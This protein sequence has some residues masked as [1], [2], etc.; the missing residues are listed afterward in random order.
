[1]PDCPDDTELA[2]F[3]NES[4]PTERLEPVSGH[5]DGCP[6]CQA[7]L[8]RLTEQTSG[9]VARYKELQPSALPDSRSGATASPDAD[10]QI[11]GARNPLAALAHAELPTVPGFDVAAEIGRGGMGVVYRARHRR[12][13]RLVALKMILAGTAADPRVVQ[14]FM[15][16]AEV[17]ARIQHPQVVQVFEVGTYQGP[18]GVPIPYLAMELLEGGSLGRKLRER[19]TAPGPRWPAPRAAAELIEGLARA[20][21][22]A[23]LRGV[24]H[25]D[26]K[27]GNI[28]FSAEPGTASA[29]PNPRAG[30]V[31]RSAPRAPGSAL[32][33]V[34]D[35]GLAKFTRDAGADLTQSGQVVGTPQYMAPEQAAGGKDL[36]P[37]ADVYALG[38]ILYECLAGRP[39]FTGAE[40]ISVLLKVVSE[41]PPD[42]RALRPEVP[43]DLA[44][45][46][47]KCLEKDPGRRYASA[48]ALADDLRL[49]LDDRPTLARPVTNR[50]RAWLWAKRNPVVAGL[51]AALGVVL[52]AAFV[53]VASLWVKAERTARDERDAKTEA[54]RAQERADGETKRAA[55]SLREVQRQKARLEFDRAVRSCEE[56]RVRDGLAQFLRTAELAEETGQADLARVARVNLAAW[57]HELPPAPRA[58]PHA[59]QPRAVAFLP[60][61][62]LV[63]AGRSGDLCLWNTA[64]GERVPYRSD[65]RLIDVLG[66]SLG[67]TYWTVAVSP[68]GR[69]L[70]AGAS[71]GLVT[72]W[73]VGSPV[74]RR[75]F[76]VSNEDAW[77]VGFSSD[78]VLWSNDGA[79]GLKRW[80][81]AAGPAPTVTALAPNSKFDGDTVQ[82]LAVSRDGKRV[83][84]GDRAARVREWDTETAAVAHT[85]PFR[86]WGAKVALV[87]S[88]A[89]RG[90]I[91]DV[92]VSPDGKRLAATGTDGTV[93]VIDLT[94]GA[95]VLEL[96]LAGAY[97][98][99]VAFAPNRPLLVATD[100]DGN[101]RL[102]RLD[103]GQAVGVPLRLPGEVTRPRFRPDSDEFAVPAGTAVYLSGAREV[104]GALLSA[105]RGLRVRGL[106]FSPTGDR[107]VA[108][109]DSGSYELFDPRTGA[110]LQYVPKVGRSPLVVR[111][112]PV[113]ARVFAGTR[114][115]V[116]WLAAPDF[117]RTN[118]VRL[119][120]T[121]GRVHRIECRSAGVYA[122]GATQVGRFDPA[123]FEPPK[124]SGPIEGV[125]EGVVLNTM[126]VRPDGR[127]VLVS[128]GDRVVVLD[129]VT[130]KPLREWRVGDGLLDARYMPDGKNVFVARRDNVAELLDATTGAPTAARPMPHTRAVTGV[131]VAA[132]GT[133]LLTGSRDGTAR[134]WDAATG[135]PLG[136]PLRHPG[137]VTYVAA[138]RDGDRVAAGTDTGHVMVWDLPPAP[139]AGTID[140]L[141]AE[142]KKK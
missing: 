36:G 118:I 21:H 2:G 128:F 42:V 61:G 83:Y 98:N 13:N 91:T 85:W 43:R 77:A 44:A 5:V 92:V 133:V 7:R 23:H 65:S 81:L 26:L 57:P 33:K 111:Y 60:D 46:T 124:L 50:E 76:R 131:D 96:S 119:S 73:D 1:M 67:V 110:R 51:I 141:R 93:W 48:E 82:T 136:A 38:A 104:P 130:L 27:P 25:R 59:D 30:P 95:V 22:A 109:D 53:T 103:T 74:P 72:L 90:W 62:R 40:P 84:T 120:D 24:I 35:F 66:R 20:V 107:L 39:P 55:E 80:D 29:E 142:L 71:D 45:V 41:R 122:M 97:G 89:L 94:T 14:R 115:G 10:T 49:F 121:L 125:R 132:R 134:F 63:A 47:M 137:P 112:D 3:L 113:R 127:E 58:F 139:A 100:G 126:S 129:A 79:N 117:R 37:A 86:G 15:I 75:S 54:L 135:L 123:A 101:A 4:L 102:W 34:L 19:N 106:D 87:R 9:A 18:S 28:L 56:G 68:D 16:E 11:L 6:R 88:W 31:P 69:T 105:G 52:V 138:T 32:P 17:L 70:A 114:A 12:L 99:G 78:T 140:A 64:T 116:E 8:D 108:A